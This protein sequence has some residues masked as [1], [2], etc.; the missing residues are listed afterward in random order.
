M[1][2]PAGTRVQAKAKT[3]L[4]AAT[5]LRW[6]GHEW[7]SRVVQGVV[8]RADGRKTLVSWKHQDNVQESSHG[9]AALEA[10]HPAQAAA[11][12]APASVVSPPPPQAPNASIASAAA[13]GTDSPDEEEELDSADPE[14]AETDEEE[15][16]QENAAELSEAQAQAQADNEAAPSAGAGP[17]VVIAH[18]RSWTLLP[19]GLM[20]YDVPDKPAYYEEVRFPV[21]VPNRVGCNAAGAR[22]EYEAFIGVA[23]EVCDFM[24]GNL[25]GEGKKFD[26][27][28]DDVVK[29][30]GI[31]LYVAEY[32][33]SGDRSDLWARRTEVVDPLGLR[34]W[35]QLGRFLPRDKFNYILNNALGLGARPLDLWQRP[36]ALTALFNRVMSHVFR[37]GEYITLDESMARS[38]QQTTYKEAYEAGHRR[39]NAAAPMQWVEEKPNPSGWWHF[40]T[41]FTPK[42]SPVPA[43]LYVEPRSAPFADPALPEFLKVG[44]M[45]LAVLRAVKPYFGTWRTI[46]ADSAYASVSLAVALLY[47]KLHL[48]GVVKTAS[49]AFPKAFL[50]GLGQSLERGQWR[51]MTS[52]VEMVAYDGTTVTATLRAVVWRD[53]KVYTLLATRGSTEAGDPKVYKRWNH[54]RGFYTRTVPRPVLLQQ[55]HANFGSVDGHNRYRHDALGLE[56][57]MRTPKMEQRLFIFHAG[58]LLV[59]AYAAWAWDARNRGPNVDFG[60]Q[61]F[62]VRLLHA[63]LMAGKPL[64]AQTVDMR[65]SRS[66]ASEATPPFVRGTPGG[67]QSVSAGKTSSAAHETAK[68]RSLAVHSKRQRAQVRCRWCG[69]KTS[70]YCVECTGD[71]VERPV[72]MH[73]ECA[74]EHAKSLAEESD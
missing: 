8:V 25:V 68:I 69:K 36:K 38:Y 46:V 15:V 33:P 20:V 57:K 47:F 48:F 56:T 67:M 74:L 42:T 13:A 72:G 32:M 34:A 26:V 17:T 63:L 22:D 73:Q 37:P 44:A 58:L 55:I 30:F 41:A 45:S 60:R 4:D 23:G 65:V 43:M 39:P 18:G 2:Y 66:L 52:P 16:A 24:V 7:K 19:V 9:A 53:Q 27:S 10:V 5:G 35:P 49:K 70:T 1:K 71:N 3:V 51:V 11:A 62:V 14:F 59:N 50:Q 54:V 61:G 29:F 64:T 21:Q 31:L 12:P 40:S 28:K 6:F